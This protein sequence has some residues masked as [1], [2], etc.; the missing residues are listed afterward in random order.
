MRYALVDDAGNI[1][2]F[3]TNVDP[4]AATRHPWRW[5]PCPE[6]PSPAYDPAK[7]VLS[8]PT[9]TVGANDVVQSWA[10]RDKTE[11]E[12]E[13]DR[14]VHV[15]A[16]DAAVLKVVFSHENRIRAL[17]GAK[18]VTMQQFKTSLKGLL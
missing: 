3:A 17:E 7:Q 15:D 14:G 16:L 18:A 2:R 11:L 1:N 13:A 6:V 12:F 8:G 5:L 9:Y 10:L 4:K